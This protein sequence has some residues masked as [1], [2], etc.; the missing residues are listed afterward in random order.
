MASAVEIPVNGVEA[1]EAGE[2]E[3]LLGRS[4]SV[5]QKDQQPIQNNL[6]I[7]S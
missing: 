3:P 6:V 1:D 2:N 7:G 4:G 5:T